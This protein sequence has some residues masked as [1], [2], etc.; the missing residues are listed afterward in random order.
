MSKLVEQKI[1]TVEEAKLPDLGEIPA[2]SPRAADDEAEEEEEEDDEDEEEEAD[3]SDEEGRRRKKRRIARS[4]ATNKRESGVKGDDDPKGSLDDPRKRRGRP[5]R[6]DTPMEARIK[7]IMKGLRKFKGPS[8]ELKIAHFEKLP[9]KTL[10]PEYFA[11][12]KNPMAIDVLKVGLP[13]AS[14]TQHFL[15]V[16]KNETDAS[17]LSPSANPNARSISPSTTL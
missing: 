14:D 8:G 6:V 10:M 4:A 16:E 7:N 3:E 15:L 9:D 13:S 2:P 17:N 1:V 5:P 11:E 12:I